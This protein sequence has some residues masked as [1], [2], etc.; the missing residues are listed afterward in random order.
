MKRKNP[1]EC[2]RLALA[3]YRAVRSELIM[4]LTDTP[5]TY[6]QIAQLGCRILEDLEYVLAPNEGE[7]GTIVDYYGD[8]DEDTKPELHTVRKYYE[9]EKTG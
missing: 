1:E 2:I 7:G 6:F 3:D 9:E 8:E 5:T 4:D